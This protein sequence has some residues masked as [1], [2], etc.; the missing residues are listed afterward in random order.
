MDMWNKSNSLRKHSI[1]HARLS[2]P[3]TT[4]LPLEPLWAKS[5]RDKH[6]H[7]ALSSS[8]AAGC[9]LQDPNLSMETVENKIQT[10]N[11]SASLCD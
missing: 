6:Q 10:S 5:R 4:T 2:D 7:Q 1:R 11:N 8:L 3:W 9:T